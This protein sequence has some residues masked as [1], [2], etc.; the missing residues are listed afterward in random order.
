[1]GSGPERSITSD[2]IFNHG[3]PLAQIYLRSKQEGREERAKKKEKQDKCII[4]WKS[5]PAFPWLKL[6]SVWEIKWTCPCKVRLVFEKEEA[7]ESWGSEWVADEWTPLLCDPPAQFLSEALRVKMEALT[8]APPLL[9]C[10]VWGVK[11]LVFL[12]LQASLPT[13]VSCLG[14]EG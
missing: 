2:L 9:L 11:L 1:M 14:T 12:Y 7:E 3:F 10:A 5:N 4:L 13:L 6:L 8:K